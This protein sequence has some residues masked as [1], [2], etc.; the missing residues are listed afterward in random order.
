[1]LLGERAPHFLEQS[2]FAWLAQDAAGRL[3]SQGLPG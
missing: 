2:G 3:H 1:M